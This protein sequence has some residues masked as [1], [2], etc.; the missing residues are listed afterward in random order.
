MAAQNPHDFDKEIEKFNKISITEGT[1]LTV[2]TGSSSIRLW[3]NLKEDCNHTQLVNTGFGGSQ[4]SDLLYFIDQTVLRFKPK[5][6]YIYEGDNDIATG[7]KPEAIIKTAQQVVDKILASDSKTKIVFISAKPSA[8]R[9]SF[10]SEYL[11]FNAL[12][13]KYCES[14]Q[15]LS[16]IDVWNPMLNDHG[17]PTSQIFVSDSLHMNRQGYLLW[18]DIICK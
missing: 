15:Q 17:L 3:E 12:L 7:K 11:A 18:K 16:Y 8:S 1:E 10:Q 4:M 2:F 5:T 9:W 6:V 13:K 14:H